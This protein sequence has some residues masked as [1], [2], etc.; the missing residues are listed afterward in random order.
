MVITTAE[1]HDVDSQ[2]DE[3]AVATEALARRFFGDAAYLSRDLTEDPET[4]ELETVFEVHCCFT[5]PE[6]KFECLV[7]RYDA[8]MNA[9]VDMVSPQILARVVLVAVPGD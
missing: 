8:F 2:L 6:E 9:F 1:A 4:G 3:A 5:D 7:E